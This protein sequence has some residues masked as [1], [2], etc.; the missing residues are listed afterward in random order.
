MGALIKDFTVTSATSTVT[1]DLT[2][3]PIQKGE[4]YE[5]TI[6][7]LPGGVRL[8]V[9]GSDTSSAGAR[10]TILANDSTTQAFIASDGM[11]LAISGANSYIKAYLKLT[12]TGYLV[13]QSVEIDEEPGIS[14]FRTMEIHSTSTITYTTVTSLGFVNGNT[15][16][17]GSR[18][19]L[20]K[21]GEKVSEVEVPSPTNIISFAGL[22]FGKTNEYLL[23]SNPVFSGSGQSALYLTANNNDTLTNYHRQVIEAGGTSITGNRQNNPY[24]HQ[25]PATPGSNKQSLAVVSLKLT[26]AGNFIYQSRNLYNY[27]DPNA[28]Y[29]QTV[30]GTS[31]YQASSITSLKIIV[32]NSTN[33]IGAGSRFELYK[34]Y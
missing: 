18:I 20:R 2:N 15:F 28:L 29:I 6:T 4:L 3:T 8:A 25:I 32:Q 16:Q 12:N 17:A 21:I 22:D 24:M 11:W 10:Q 30:Y 14:T 31:T 23:V 9:N 33:S 1:F 7:S 27:T 26:D 19:Q 34:L 13:S 5:L